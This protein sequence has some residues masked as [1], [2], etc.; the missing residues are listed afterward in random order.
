VT[1][2]PGVRV[3]KVAAAV[4]ALARWVTLAKEVTAYFPVPGG[5][6]TISDRTGILAEATFGV[7][8]AQHTP[9]NEELRF[10]LGSISK[11]FTA[12]V[13]L[14]LV[15]EG[16]I[17]FDDP[18]GFYLPWAELGPLASEITIRRLLTHSSGTAVGA[19]A[20]PDDIAEIVNSARFVPVASPVTFHYSNLGYQMLGEV[21]RAVSGTPLG[22]C[23]VRRILEPLAMTE[24]L[25]RVTYADWPTMATGHW[26]TRPDQPW[27]PGDPLSAAVWFELDSGSGNIVSTSRDLARFS[28]AYLGA[29]LGEPVLDGQGQPV[30]DR[31]TF[32]RITGTLAEGGE[33]CHVPP[34]APPVTSSRY[35]LGVNVETVG[36]ATCVT[37]GGGMVGYS[38]FW[39]VDVEHD[40]A[41]STLT[42]ANGDAHVSQLLTR[43]GH[44]EMLRQL[45]GEDAGQMASLNPLVVGGEEWCNGTFYSDHDGAELVVRQGGAGEAVRVEYRGRVGDLFHL[46]TGRWATNHPDLRRFHLDPV[47]GDARAWTWGPVTFATTPPL[48]RV[49][50]NTNP[51]VGHYRSY[52]PW[53][54]E[55]RIIER[56]DHLLLC[57]PGGTE[58][59][60]DELELRE[61]A[62]CEWSLGDDESAPERLV[63]GPIIGGEVVSLNRGGCAY[64]RVF[65]P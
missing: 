26:P 56:A 15:D 10:E 60:I 3:T 12:W 47:V 2:C 33:P 5:V 40:V 43:A 46:S 55:F 42:N 62:P 11:A 51:L 41:L 64:S 28:A 54:P 19:D 8:D 4:A 17:H 63:T 39:L 35:G 18:V 48:E 1:D 30:M 44:G 21:V 14:Q 52:S 23:V 20:V 31:H 36:D 27:L 13:V 49:V 16:L 53:Y 34:G 25:A 61:V 29:A 50:P 24:T 9:M 38:T 37:H 22:E 57:A 58:S 32:D 6:L 45:H 7:A 59:P 65:S